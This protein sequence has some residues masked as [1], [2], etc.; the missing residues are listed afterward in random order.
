MKLKIELIPKTSFY[1]NVRSEVSKKEWDSIRKKCYMMA[2][3]KCEICGG[4]GKNQG[5]KHDV[6]CHEIWDFNMGDSTQ[7]LAGFIA[8]CPMCHKSKHYG[9]AQL[10]GFE[11]MVIEHMCLVNRVNEEDVLTEVDKAF[12][13]W[14]KRNQIQWKLDI[15]YL[16]LYDKI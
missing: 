3:H 8:L 14:D 12:K 10:Q 15:S 9:L 1:S 2:G 13:Q 6:E 11:E 7:K 5:Y 16:E 4:S